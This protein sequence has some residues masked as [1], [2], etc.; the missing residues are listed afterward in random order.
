MSMEA[1]LRFSLSS[2]PKAFSKSSGVTSMSNSFGMFYK[3]DH[4]IQKENICTYDS[5]HILILSRLA[6]HLKIGR[7]IGWFKTIKNQTQICLDI[8]SGFERSVYLC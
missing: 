6:A 2:F 8:D 4:F 5:F 1:L 7:E 3:K